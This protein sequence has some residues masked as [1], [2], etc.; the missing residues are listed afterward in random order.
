MN[1]DQL[2][3]SCV[4]VSKSDLETD[5]RY[6]IYMKHPLTDKVDIIYRRFSHK[7]SNQ[8]HSDGSDIGERYAFKPESESE[9]ADIAPPDE[10]TCNGVYIIFYHKLMWERSTYPKF[11]KLK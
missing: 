10:D 6:F 11:F 2:E 7:M 3:E 4:E 1:L 8:K 9:V 5:K